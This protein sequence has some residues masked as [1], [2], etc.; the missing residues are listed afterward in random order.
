MPGRFALSSDPITP[1]EESALQAWVKT[2]M[3]WWHWLP[4]FWLFSTKDET[5]T[6]EMIRDKFFE[7]APTARCVVLKVD[8]GTWYG[9]TRPNSRGEPME[10]WLHKHWDQSAADS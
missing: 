2:R 10:A 6:A 9:M 1:E 3:A 8:S 5:V 4:N 7:I